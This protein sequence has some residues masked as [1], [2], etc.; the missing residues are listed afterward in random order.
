MR[1]F[2]ELWADN[3]TVRARVGWA[4]EPE[5]SVMGA[6]QVFEHGSA[7][8]TEQQNYPLH[9]QGSGCNRKHLGALCRYVCRTHGYALE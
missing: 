7:L 2:G 3:A 4:I 6:F 9:V 8:W 1:G 5:Q